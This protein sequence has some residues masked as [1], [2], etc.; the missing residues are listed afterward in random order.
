MKAPSPP[1]RSRSSRSR[2]EC[3]G[4]GQDPP[5]WRCQAQRDALRPSTEHRSDR[6][7]DLKSHAEWLKP[8][9]SHAATWQ[10]GSTSTGHPT[11]ELPGRTSAPRLDSTPE[12]QEPHLACSNWHVFVGAVTRPGRAL[13]VA[14]QLSRGRRA[15][16][17]S[18]CSVGCAAARRCSL[19]PRLHS[20]RRLDLRPA[21]AP[22]GPDGSHPSVTAIAHL[23]IRLPASLSQLHRRP[24]R[25]AR[26]GL[27]HCRRIALKTPR[28]QSATSPLL[29]R[30]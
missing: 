12:R 6:R 1:R 21:G 28:A 26:I 8:V 3:A 24:S 11:T 23:G 22:A 5:I 27:L 16:A 13:R 17:C 10:S 7:P 25:H 4:C 2:R 19:T 30:W 18:G 29:R 14:S 20:C 9:T 15:P